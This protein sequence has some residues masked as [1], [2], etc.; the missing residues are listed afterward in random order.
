MHITV[1]VTSGS[2][3]W[4]CQQH[5]SAAAHTPPSLAAREAGAVKELEAHLPTSPSLAVDEAEAV[6]GTEEQ[7]Q[8]QHS[9]SLALTEEQELRGSTSC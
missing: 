9:T 7:A 2:R 1:A 5:A 6:D 3:G 8:G 4:V